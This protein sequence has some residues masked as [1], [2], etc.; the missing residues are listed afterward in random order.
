[1][2][3]VSSTQKASESTVRRAWKRWVVWS[4]GLCTL[5]LST[6]CCGCVRDILGSPVAISGLTRPSVGLTCSNKVRIVD[7][8]RWFEL[9]Q[10]WERQLNTHALS[11]YLDD[12]KSAS[13]ALC[14]ADCS[15][16]GAS[17]CD[18]Y[19]VDSCSGFID[20]ACYTKASGATGAGLLSGQINMNVG[21][22]EQKTGDAFFDW[23]KMCYPPEKSKDP[24]VPGVCVN[25]STAY[26]AKLD[27]V[28]NP[29]RFDTVWMVRL[30]VQEGRNV[31]QLR[32]DAAVGYGVEERR[33]STIPNTKRTAVFFG[34]S[35]ILYSQFTLRTTPNPKQTEPTRVLSSD[36]EVRVLGST[37]EYRCC[38]K[39]DKR[40]GKRQISCLRQ[41]DKKPL[42]PGAPNVC[43]T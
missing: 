43:P 9:V 16:G 24:N 2:Q 25:G 10:R 22:I 36:G 37:G 6:G 41:S 15:T 7:R 13:M 20:L 8:I 1:M 30:W 11:R 35:S 28:R 5:L 40:T 29:K 23:Q 18:C 17:C 32:L 38:F 42:C 39:V 14:N 31:A 34:D 33:N 26:H 27:D 21:T 19:Q 4:L 3:D 12:A